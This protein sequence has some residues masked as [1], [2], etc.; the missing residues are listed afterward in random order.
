MARP[1]AAAHEGAT[2]QAWQ[3]GTLPRG[4]NG[5]VRALPSR[6]RHEAAQRR[7]GAIAADDRAARGAAEDSRT[8]DTKEW[9]PPPP[10]LHL[11]HHPPATWPLSR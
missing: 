10:P 3:G 9:S 2:W 6:D 1:T 11:H 7:F 8:G 4:D 5:H